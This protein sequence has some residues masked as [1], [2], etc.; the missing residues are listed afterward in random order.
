MRPEMTLG[1]KRIRRQRTEHRLSMSCVS[2][3][4]ECIVSRGEIFRALRQ[5]QSAKR[6]NLG[7]YGGYSGVK[8][9]LAC[10][11]SKKPMLST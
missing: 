7:G 11:L 5:W 10:N 1:R 8:N 3:A 6:S 4:G 2:R 9:A